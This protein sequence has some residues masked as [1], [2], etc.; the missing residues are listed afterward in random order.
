VKEIFK[1]YCRI[2]LSSINLLNKF[3]VIFT[4]V[5]RKGE[6]KILSKKAILPLALLGVLFVSLFASSSV[7]AWIGPP[8]SGNRGTEDTNFELFGP[9]VDNILMKMYAGTDSEWLALK[10]GEIDITDWSLTPAWLKDFL[11]GTEPHVAVGDA[12][13]EFG[14]YDLDMNND[15]WV[16]MDGDDVVG[17]EGDIRNPF[18]DPTIITT[19]TSWYPYLPTG[20]PVTRG[21]VMR[22]AV[23][24]LIDRAAIIALC[25]SPPTYNVMWTHI[26]ECVLFREKGWINDDVMKYPYSPALAA[27]LL[28][29]A[30]FVDTDASGKRNFDSDGDGDIDATDADMSLELYQRQDL[31]RDTL[32]VWVN[33]KLTAL[34]IVVVS[35]SVSGGGAWTNCMLLKKHHM[36]TAGWILGREP[37]TAYFLY[38][39]LFYWHPGDPPNYNRVNDTDFDYY[40][41]L[42]AYP[43]DVETAKESCL[44]CQE[45]MNEPQN[46]YNIAVANSWMQKAFKIYTEDGS[47][48]WR[49]LINAPGFGINTAALPLD[50]TFNAHADGTETGGTLKYGWKENTMP[51]SLNPFQYSWYWDA[52]CLFRI[53]E[54]LTMANPYDTFGGGPGTWPP[55]DIPWLAWD[56]IIDNSGDTSK[57]TFYLRDDVYF[58]DGTQMTAKD[59]YYTVQLGLWM[60]QDHLDQGWE[61]LPPWFYGNIVDLTY[62]GPTD[63]LGVGVDMPDGPN[64]YTVVF[65]YNI[66]SMWAFWWC[67][68]GLPIVPKAKWW[69]VFYPTLAGV[70]GFAPDNQMIGTG[71]F[72]VYPYHVYSPVDPEVYSPGEYVRLFKN[73]D[74]WDS[75][76]N[77]AMLYRGIQ[78]IVPGSKYVQI[79]NG[80]NF[81]VIMD[82]RLV[83]PGGTAT[84]FNIL[85][86]AGQT[87]FIS[88]QLPPGVGLIPGAFN[89]VAVTFTVTLPAPPKGPGAWITTVGPFNLDATY[90]GDQV[91]T[92]G[93]PPFGFPD[94]VVNW[95]DLNRLATQFGQVRSTAIWDGTL[96]GGWN[97]DSVGTGAAPPFGFPDGVVNW[98]DLNRL[99]TYF[100]LPAVL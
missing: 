16:N 83:Y 21:S 32:G 73:T 88:M 38:N 72:K 96:P 61:A 35:H 3:L 76:E 2:E 92:G 59:V 43:P 48:Y 18:G 22:L 31:F 27:Q 45:V 84:K 9:R 80:Q 77:P 44:A 6:R 90:L 37:T 81:G 15:P 60:A 46:V 34:N 64:G 23:A 13:G 89:P 36:Y 69:D 82:V 47:T 58:H 24:H 53:Y 66:K 52:E 39:S 85:L 19:D 49:G 98:K 99:A 79:S 17:D 68:A 7:S 10:N 97:S 78:V 67:G 94:G 54:P 12:G 74:Y 14:M 70:D 91:G 25:G 8:Y 40:S 11:D 26:C 33:T 100:G 41:D 93:T 4:R 29:G 20:S 1:A 57:F 30:G 50:T 63:T 55:G 62:E 56:W 65:N 42:V 95:K 87:R 5:K 28:N 71:P 51:S 75:Y 86:P